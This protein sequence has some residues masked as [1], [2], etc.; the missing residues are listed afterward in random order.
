[1]Q[2]ISSRNEVWRY[3]VKSFGTHRT[4]VIKFFF[5]G[6]PLGV[7]AFAATILAEQALGVDWHGGHHADHG[8][9]GHGAGHH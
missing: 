4:R 1:M 9:S 8:D 6:F 3:D 5:R 2:L 7:A